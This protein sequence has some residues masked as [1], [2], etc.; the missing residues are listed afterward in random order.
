IERY[1]PVHDQGASH[2]KSRLIRQ[3][4]FENAAYV[5]LVLRSYELWRELEARTGKHLMTITGLLLAGKESTNVVAGSRRSAERHDLPVEY[6]TAADI[7]RRYPASRPRADEVGIFEREG[8]VI[9]PER[10]VHALLRSATDAGARLRFGERVVDWHRAGPHTLRVTLDDGTSIDAKQLVLTVGPWFEAIATRTGV[11]VNVQRN[12]QAWFAPGSTDFTADRFP[13]F[14]LDREGLPNVIYGMPDFGDGVK[15]AFHCRGVY[16]KPDQLERTISE[17]DIVPIQTAMETWLPGASQTFL[18]AKACMY[19]L[20]PD[21][22]FAIGRHP[23]DVDVI[24]AGGFSGHGFKFAPVVG[25]I[26]AELL[27]DGASR[28]DIGFLSPDRFARAH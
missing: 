22:H 24:V 2:G 6:L 1:W 15:A 8:G 23:E 3:A 28:F 11:P 5:P 17:S 9:F 20:T 16:T 13:A 21:E 14:L 7:A 19:A 18:S 27:F 10:A 4:Y 26:A 25:Q 12:V